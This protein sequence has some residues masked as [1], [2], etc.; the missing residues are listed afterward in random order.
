MVLTKGTYVV[1][2]AKITGIMTFGLFRGF[3]EIML[4]GVS[5]WLTRELAHY[6]LSTRFK[7][8]LTTIKYGCYFY[9]LYYTTWTDGRWFSVY[10]LMYLFI[11][12]TLSFSDVC[13][14]VPSNTIT[15]WLGRVS[16]PLYVFHG[17]FRTGLQVMFGRD[18][19]KPLIYISIILCYIISIIMMYLVPKIEMVV[20]Q[21]IK[22]NIRH[23]ECRSLD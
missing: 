19:D 11:A 17:L 3:I 6:Q 2:Y 14:R 12:I 16:L 18:A 4:G 15:K 23:I 9:I 1:P 7:T 8:L 10:A 20:T 5:I 13:Y 21:S 22:R